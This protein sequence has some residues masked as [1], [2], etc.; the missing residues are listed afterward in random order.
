MW[1]KLGSLA[2]ELR[3]R[4]LRW[5]REFGVLRV[6]RIANGH[7]LIVR[8]GATMDGES[9]L[10]ADARRDAILLERDAARSLLAQFLQRSQEIRPLMADQL[11]RLDATGDDWA[12]GTLLHLLMSQS[13][14]LVEGVKKMQDVWHGMSDMS[15]SDRSLIWMPDWRYMGTQFENIVKRWSREVER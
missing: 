12:P 3:R 1:A 11:D 9:L 15:V 4:E 5:R 2:G 13:D 6:H 8:G 7:V 14:S 10:E